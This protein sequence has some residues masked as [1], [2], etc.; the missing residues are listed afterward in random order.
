MILP[1]KLVGKS[2]I[3]LVNEEDKTKPRAQQYKIFADS[4]IAFVATRT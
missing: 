3:R 1:R 2:S 4:P